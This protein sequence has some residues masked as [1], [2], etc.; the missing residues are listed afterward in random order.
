MEFS[1][2]I[3][4]VQLG[5]FLVLAVQSLKFLGVSDEKWLKLGPV[6]AAAAFGIVYAVELFVP[7]SKP[8]VDIVFQI[9][10]AIMTAVLG[11]GYIAKPVAEAFGLKVSSGEIEE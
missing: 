5:A 11:Y 3:A 6:I 2:V 8:I 4:G 10:V 1:L 9:V 7:A